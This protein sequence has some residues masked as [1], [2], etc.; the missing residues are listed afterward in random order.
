MKAMPFPHMRSL[1]LSLVEPLYALLEERH[2]TRAANRCGMSQSAMSRA[3]GRLR[4]ALADELLVRSGGAYE[5]TPCGDQLNVDLQGPLP[6]LDAAVRGNR[7][8]PATSTERFCI[9]TTDYAA[10]ILIPRKPA[11]RWRR[12]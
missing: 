7:F 3:L 12:A 4:S 6:H 11:E 1:D 5:R 10:A 2:A 8:D 9:A